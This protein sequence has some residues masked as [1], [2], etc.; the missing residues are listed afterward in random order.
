MRAA[1]LLLVVGCSG[2][3]DLGAWGFDEY[4]SAAC[5]A[6]DALRCSGWLVQAC[7]DAAW[8]TLVDCG[9][10]GMTCAY[11]PDPDSGETGP[12][13]VESFYYGDVDRP[14]ADCS[15][16]DCAMSDSE[17]CQ[18]LGGNWTGTSCVYSDAGGD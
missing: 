6:E 5:E 10:R 16:C 18:C 12:R 14:G 13:C 2:A 11:A 15:G 17:R 3:N 1:A 9:R 7:R 8:I 4:S